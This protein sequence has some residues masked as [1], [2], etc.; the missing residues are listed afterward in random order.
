MKGSLR[1]ITLEGRIKL[2]V[3]SALVVLS[4]IVSIIT[5]INVILPMLLSF[6]GDV[7]LMKNRDCFHNRSERDFRTGILF[8]M[9]A[10]IAYADVMKV[11]EYSWIKDAMILATMLLIF[12]VLCYPNPCSYYKILVIILLIYLSTHPIRKARGKT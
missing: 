11:D 9:F 7:S 5:G 2:G 6:G 12:L 10:H 8:F 1:K 3:T 4:T